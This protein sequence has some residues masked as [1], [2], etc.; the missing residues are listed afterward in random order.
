MGRCACACTLLVLHLLIFHN[1]KKEKSFNYKENRNVKKSP[2]VLGT[3]GLVFSGGLI[4]WNTYSTMSSPVTVISSINDD[5][6]IPKYV[7]L[8][9]P[10]RGPGQEIKDIKSMIPKHLRK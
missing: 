1:A 10:F 6:T 4:Y 3:T 7:K 5:M 8:K 2:I 9:Q